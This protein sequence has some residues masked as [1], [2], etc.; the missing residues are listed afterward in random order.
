MIQPFWT[1]SVRRGGKHRRGF[2]REARYVLNWS[3]QLVGFTGQD[4][5]HFPLQQVPEPKKL[6]FCVRILV[7][8]GLPPIARFRCSAHTNLHLHAW[9]C[10]CGSTSAEVEL[11]RDS[12]PT[13]SAVF[14]VPIVL[15]EALA[16]LFSHW[17]SLQ[18]HVVH[19]EQRI[20]QAQA[21]IKQRQKHYRDLQHQQRSLVLGAL[22]LSNKMMDVG[23]QAVRAA[24]HIDVSARTT[25]QEP[26]EENRI[27]LAK[28]F[29]MFDTPIIP[30]R[31]LRSFQQFA[32]ISY[33][34]LHAVLKESRPAG[35]EDSSAPA[36]ADS[37]ASKPGTDSGLPPLRGPNS[38]ARARMSHQGTVP[39]DTVSN[40]VT[41][42][43]LVL[44][45]LH[46][47]AAS[48]SAPESDVCYFVDTGRAISP[49]LTLTYSSSLSSRECAASVLLNYVVVAFEHALQV[50]F[51]AGH[52]FIFIMLNHAVMHSC[53]YP[54]LFFCFEHV[55]VAQITAPTS[56]TLTCLKIS[57]Q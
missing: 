46:K 56:L 52:D 51:G 13:G 10:A 16:P 50:E 20:E 39:I 43:G 23:T 38:T 34:D 57:S 24:K 4:R 48:L 21:R 31:P 12:V 26:N 7:Y 41:L 47:T 14:V 19:L 27:R 35:L 44:D 30:P 29:T 1:E 54:L 5:V 36:R 55:I 6:R 22:E 32:S 2:V 25:T 11:Y 8:S 49:T 18:A 17:R 9:V 45:H 37:A 33:T 15:D 42:R 3:V 28:K 40:N 53:V